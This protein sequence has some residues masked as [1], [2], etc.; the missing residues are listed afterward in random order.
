VSALQPQHRRAA[1]RTTHVAAACG[2]TRHRAGPRGGTGRRRRGNELEQTAGG[3]QRV[4]ILTRMFDLPTQCAVCRGWSARRICADCLQRHAAKAPRCAGCAITV[5]PGVQRCGA[6]ITAPLP[7]SHVVAAV[8]YGFPWSNLLGAFKFNAALELGAALAALLADAVHDSAAPLPQCV[9]AVP[10]GQ[11]RL[12]QRG[13][14]QAWELAR[15]VAASLQLRSQACVLVRRVETPHLADLPREGR[16]RA[17]RGA[18]ALHPG[19]SA[20]LRGRS[21]ALVDDVMTTGATAA[22]AARTLLDA[23]AMSVQL[24]V[25]ART[26]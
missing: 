17:I 21:V 1:L 9:T 25:L 19:A 5:A 18:F 16:A 14:N 4:S 2:S 13:M 15:R 11:D 10:L 23:G 22:E 26:P 6:C 24:W 12:A 8:D 7:F 3:H 20:A